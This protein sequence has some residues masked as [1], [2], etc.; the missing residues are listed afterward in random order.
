MKR[1][2]RSCGILMLA[3]SLSFSLLAFLPQKEAAAVEYETQNL[4]RLYYDEEAPY[5]NETPAEIYDWRNYENDGWEKWSVPLGN[6]YMG[7]VVFG[8]TETERLQITENSLSTPY[9]GG[10]VGGGMTNFGEIY[11]DFGHTNS[12]VKNYSRDLLLDEGTAH[13]NYTYNGVN[14]SREL[15]ASYPDK[16]TVVKLTADQAGKIDFTLRTEIPYLED[17]YTDSEH[18]NALRGKTGT[19]TSADDTITWAGKFGAYE[20]KYE[21]QVKVIPEGGTVTASADDNGNGCLKVSGANTAYVIIGVGTNY[22][23]GDSAIFAAANGKEELAKYPA[24]HQKVTELM[25]AASGK[26]Y[27]QLLANHQA[28]YKELFGRVKLNLGGT[29]GGK[30]TDQLVEDYKSGRFNHYLE[31]LY[32]QYG[33][34][35]LICSSRKGTLP[36]NLQ[37]IWNRYK[38]PPWSAGYWHNINI[39]MNYWP[40][41][42][43]NLAELFD[44]YIDYY[45]AYLPKA[46]KD[47]ANWMARKHPGNAELPGGSGWSIATGAWPCY[48]SSVSDSVSEGNSNAALMAKC[49]SDYYEFTKDKSKLEEV[50]YPAVLGSAVFMTKVMEPH[51]GLLLADPSASPEQETTIGG[52][53]YVTVGTAWDQQNAYEVHKDAIAMA[54]VLGKEN[55]PEVKMLEE[56]IGKLDPVQVGASGQIKEFREENYYGDI[57]EYNHRH[58][59]HLVGLY[60]GSLINETTPAWFDAAAV[61]MT[62][63]GDKSTGW[64]MAH[65][66]NLWAR[67]KRG[68]RAYDLYRQ[69]LQTG[70]NNNLWDVHPPFQIDGNLGGTAGVAEMLLQSHEGYIEPLAAIPSAWNTGSYSGLVAR[71][72][73][74]VAASWSGG[75][76]NEIRVTSKAGEQCR[77]KYYNIGKATV[78]ASDGSFVSVTKESN[79]LISFSTKKGI[80]YTIS[81][82]PDYTAV[83]APGQLQVES[84]KDTASTVQLSWKASE[85]EGVTY[86]IYR[87]EESEPDYTLIASQITDLSY[88]YKVPGKS[89]GKQATYRVTTVKDNRESD[90]VAAVTEAVTVSAPQTVIGWFLDDSTLQISVSPVEEAAGYRLYEK[91]NGTWEKIQTSS[92]STLVQSGAEKEVS[93]G[94]SAFRGRWESDIKEAVIT[95]AP[96]AEPEDNVLLHQTITSTRNT[97][98]THYLENALDGN[99]STR[100]AVRD[101]AEPYSVTVALDG[102]YL[103]DTLRI[104][105][106]KPDE[107]G[108]RSSNTTV[109]VKSGGNWKTVVSG[110]SLKEITENG[111]CTEFSL[112]NAIA[113]ELRITFENTSGYNTAASIWELQCSGLQL[114]E[115]LV[116]DNVFLN[117]SITGSKGA[118]EP[119]PF[120][121]ALDGSLSTRYALSDSAEPYYVTIT[122]DDTY[123]LDTLKIYEFNEVAQTRSGKTK[124]EAMVNG[125]WETVVENRALNDEIDAGTSF[126]MGRRQATAVRITFQNTSGKAQSATIKEI[127]CSGVR[128]TNSDKSALAQALLLASAV[129]SDTLTEDQLSEWEKTLQTAQTAMNSKKV[130]QETVDEAAAALTALAKKYGAK[131]PEAPEARNVQISGIAMAGETLTAS[132]DYYDANGDKETKSKYLWEA[133]SDGTVWTAIEKADEK[134]LTVTKDLIGKLVRV[135]VRTYTDTEPAVSAY[136]SSDAFGPI[137]RAIK[138]VTVTY[139]ANGTVL[140]N[141]E[142]FVSG[143][144]EELDVT[145]GLTLTITPDSGYM[146]SHVKVNGQPVIPQ[147]DGTVFLSPV[148]GETKVEVVFDVYAERHP[149]VIAQPSSD[150]FANINGTPTIYAYGRLNLFNTKETVAYGMCVWNKK[151]PTAVLRLPACDSK[152]GEPAAAVPGQAY[153]IKMYGYAIVPEDT[154]VVQ[155]YVGDAT[156]EEIELSYTE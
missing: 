83:K 9:L 2:T 34:Y 137:T 61:S 132:Y 58:V 90:G 73:F 21:G 108:T 155:P 119:Y 145:D 130:S 153:A 47:T 53:Y 115:S 43:T 3:L 126:D 149:E 117:Q 140:V 41:F 151:D 20:V 122:L 156:G 142:D 91:R 105:E 36:P 104:Y 12:E 28:D 136:A 120:K 22:P 30:T 135:R 45:R 52:G 128:Q 68:E 99:L 39:Q 79:D 92:Y 13:V 107:G 154:Y 80:S 62:K 26:S 27:E 101:N 44:S 69:L 40:V 131:M 98:D 89:I 25:T 54:K 48:V 138:P 106:F 1:G 56:R 144:T 76:M 4:L 103:L 16:V 141:G 10:K 152:D 84:D 134:T 32:F 15:F 75:Q 57:G 111:Q 86:S 8:R 64:A 93:Y 116:E 113:T 96:S 114:D 11:M 97:I 82:I 46:E 129:D 87:A 60:P 112:G 42:N 81:A 125:A 37:G 77:L 71:G 19:V 6:G 110:Q 59:S 65:R 94:V 67:T 143:K 150:I 100:Y 147:D 72:N 14:Y 17:Y 33:R 146:I 139:T 7:V 102:T 127:Q 66:L 23:V 95:S 123:L 121:N 31:A 51:D 133:S 109:E 70:T 55:T 35:L 85:D 63:R 29:D 49:F 88:T 118:Y 38:N 24:P 18:G 148:T 78:T 124:I 74:E 50:L 5:G